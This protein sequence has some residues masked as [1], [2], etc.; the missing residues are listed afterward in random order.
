[1]SAKIL[2]AFAFAV[3]SA[4]GCAAPDWQAKAEQLQ[5]EN[6]DL[7]RQKAKLEADHLAARARIDVLERN[8]FAASPAVPGA[9]AGVTPA[10][11][12][13]PLELSGKVEIRRRGN[14]TVIDVPSDV[15]FASGSSML[16][17]DGDKAMASIVDYI[18]KHHPGG[19]IRVEGHSDSDPIRRTKSK[20]HCNWELSFER[21]HAVT[22]FL[23]EKGRFDPSRVVC[24][25]HGEFHPLDPANKAKNRRVEIVVA[26]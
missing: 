5:R 26:N 20:Y 19:L 3:A 13:M 6:E 14:D 16:N 1:M 23:V 11:Y 7:E 12:E 17:R 22:H 18:K 21:S 25:A 15:F 2:T 24:E 9:K 10:P 4:V 8:R